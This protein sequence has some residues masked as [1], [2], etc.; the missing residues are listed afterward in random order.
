MCNNDTVGRLITFVFLALECRQRLRIHWT[1]ERRGR[2]S[3][4]TSLFYL[5]FP[6]SFIALND[7]NLIAFCSAFF[8]KKSFGGPAEPYV[9][10]AVSFIFGEGPKGAAASQVKEEEGGVVEEVPI[11]DEGSREMGSVK[12]C[13]TAQRSLCLAQ[14]VDHG[15]PSSTCLTWFHYTALERRKGFRLHWSGERRG[16]VS[17]NFS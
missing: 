16:R 14:L 2:V 13:P 15:T 10:Q 8:H 17:P 4:T 5:S 3:I 6:A 12:V 1:T 9:G 11:E 7:T